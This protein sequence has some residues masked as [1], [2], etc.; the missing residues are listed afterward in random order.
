MSN[1]IICILN[2]WQIWNNEPD[3]DWHA[4][5]VITFRY[6]TL[7]RPGTRNSSVYLNPNVSHTHADGRR[8]QYIE[9][10]DLTH[11]QNHF[12]GAVSVSSRNKILKSFRLK[13]VSVRFETVEM[14]LI[15]TSFNFEC[16][17]RF[18]KF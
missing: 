5:G 3:Q 9:D 14:F 4:S 1:I 8:L 10:S 2:C 12:C 15:E 18:Q 13:T 6:T 16:Y 17:Q 7:V 11:C